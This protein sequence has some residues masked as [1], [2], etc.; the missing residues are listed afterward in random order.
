M[1]LD[2]KELFRNCNF[3]QYKG[4]FPR[5]APSMGKFIISSTRKHEFVQSCGY[6]RSPVTIEPGTNTLNVP[7]DCSLNETDIRILNPQGNTKITSQI[8]DSEP[9]SLFEIQKPLPLNK[10]KILTIQTLDLQ[11][12]ISSLESEHQNDT[13]FNEHLE[14]NSITYI[15]SI[16]G[17]LIL[18]ILSSIILY[19][20]ITLLS[21]VVQ[22]MRRLIKAGKTSHRRQPKIDNV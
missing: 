9:I 10:L 19:L 20:K 4:H 15:T 14:D 3:T 22:S 8:L 11:S 6:N 2:P 18:I 21:P 17:L 13:P 16:V 12:R 1:L 5:I 7:P